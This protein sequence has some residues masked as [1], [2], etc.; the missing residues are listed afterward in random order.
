MNSLTVRQKFILINLIEKG[1]L[2]NKGLSQQIDISERT[3][4]RE[5]SSINNWLKQYSLRVSDSGGE[6]ILSGNRKNIETVRTLFDGVPDLW[7][8]TQEQ[9]QILI[10]AQLLLSKEP[11][12]SAYFSCQFN[13]VEGTVI[14]YLDKIES[15]LRTKNLK[16][17]RRRGYGLEIIGSVW[18]KRNAFAELLYSYKSISELLAF[19]Y[20]D[21][22]DYSLHAFFSV[23]FGENMI[24]SVKG[25][26]KKL[27]SEESMP[28]AN[29]VDY[30]ST[31]IHM[32]LAIVV[33][34]YP[35]G[36]DF[37]TGNTAYILIGIAGRNDEHLEILSAIAIVCQNEHNVTKLRNAA[38]KEEIIRILTEGDE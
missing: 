36:V 30:F 6:L 32:L 29:D 18:N 31:F 26:L 21:S 17:I 9:R 7:M 13:V 37:G 8:L 10:T 25:M 11:I 20:E 5:V 19:L 27:Y 38:A 3:I 22:N 28:K 23:T 33:V 14:F 2:I 4:M 16:L 15:W 34:Q 35:E 12:K 1:P 24:A